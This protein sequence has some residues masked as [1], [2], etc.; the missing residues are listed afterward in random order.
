MEHL[1]EL[2]P[3]FTAGIFLF[4]T[5]S[6]TFI[7]VDNKIDPLKKGVARLEAGQAKLEAGQAK[8]T[9]GLFKLEAKLDQLLARS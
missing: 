3:L 1:S 5:L 9:A 2:T 6:G 7:I 4:A 8:L